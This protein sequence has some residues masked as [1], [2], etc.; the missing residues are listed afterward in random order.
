MIF[1]PSHYQLKAFNSIKLKQ[2]RVGILGTGKAWEGE[3]FQGVL[4]HC[5]KFCLFHWVR[6]RLPGSVWPWPGQLCTQQLVFGFHQRG[7]LSGDLTGMAL[8]ERMGI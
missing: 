5:C 6:R 7:G 1:C 4:L 2:D 8:S 3:G